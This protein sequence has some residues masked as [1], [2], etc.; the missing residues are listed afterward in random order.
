MQKSKL[1]LVHN[2]FKHGK[3]LFLFKIRRA[4][5]GIYDVYIKSASEVTSARSLTALFVI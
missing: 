5:A 2:S 1:N 4:N 3:P